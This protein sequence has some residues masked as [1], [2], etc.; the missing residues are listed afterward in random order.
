MKIFPGDF[1]QT[2]SYLVCVWGGG[3]GG[4]KIYRRAITTNKLIS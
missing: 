1:F 2:Q 4:D 3:G